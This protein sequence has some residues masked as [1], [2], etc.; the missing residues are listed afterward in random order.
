[1]AKGIMIPPPPW[2]EEIETI[3]PP[4]WE[5]DQSS[6]LMVQDSDNIPPPPWEEQDQPQ[7]DE[8]QFQSW[9]AGHAKTRGL[10][11]NPDDPEHYYDYRAAFKAGAGPGPDGHWP[12]Q[13]KTE[14]H[15]RTIVDG[16]NTITGQPVNE[17]PD[18]FSNAARKAVDITNAI[19]KPIYLT[20]GSPL[21]TPAKAIASLET[22]GPALAES[23]QKNIGDWVSS[24]PPENLSPIQQKERQ[25]EKALLAGIT[26]TA[27]EILP[28]S[29][30]QALE[31]ELFGAGT[32]ALAK[33]VRAGS[34]LNKFVGEYFPNLAEA[35]FKE[36]TVLTP[37]MQGEL[38]G[39]IFRVKKAFGVPQESG[40]I[41]YARELVRKAE[42]APEAERKILFKRA[43][44]MDSSIREEMIKARG[45]D[46][47]KEVPL[48]PEGSS[49]PKARPIDI[50]KKPVLQSERPLSDLVK[51]EQNIKP[52]E[53]PQVDLSG[54]PDQVP[55]AQPEQSVAVPT[56]PAATG[57]EV[58]PAKDTL[59]MTMKEPE[60]MSLI[61]R[62]NSIVKNSKNFKDFKDQMLSD[63]KLIDAVNFFETSLSEIH[64][65]KNEKNII[66]PISRMEPP[67]VH[68]MM[69]VKI[70][71]NVDG[72]INWGFS[73]MSVYSDGT[74]RWLWINPSTA[75]KLHGEGKTIKEIGE[76]IADRDKKMSEELSKI[77]PSIKVYGNAQKLL[78]EITE[79][80]PVPPEVI[81]DYPDLGKSE[82]SVLP[83]VNLVKRNESDS[84]YA[85]YDVLSDAGDN[86]GHVTDVSVKGEDDGMI[87]LVPIIEKGKGYGQ[88][89]YIAMAKL[90]PDKRIISGNLSPDA[91]RMW[92]S[93][94]KKGFADREKIGEYPNGETEWQYIL[95]KYADIQNF[96]TPP[97]K[98]PWE[99]TQRAYVF[100]PEGSEPN[101]SSPYAKE[102]GIQ[103][104]SPVYPD[105]RNKAIS[106]HANA[107]RV[108]LS[109][110]KPVPQEVL[111][112]YPELA[113]PSP[114][115]KLLP[116]KTMTS[117]MTDAV[118]QSAI[119]LKKEIS[120][121]RYGDKGK[122]LFEF[123]GTTY[124]VDEP[125]D[126]MPVG[127]SDQSKSWALK[128]VLNENAKRIN[129]VSKD[130]EDALNDAYD[131]IVRVTETQKRLL[132]LD[133]IYGNGTLFPL[134]TK[135][136]FGRVYNVVK[137]LIAEKSSASPVQKVEESIPVEKQKEFTSLKIDE[138]DPKLIKAQVIEKLK[139]IEKQFPIEQSLIQSVPNVDLALKQV[140]TDS[141]NAPRKARD[142]VDELKKISVGDKKFRIKIPDDGT[143]TVEPTLYA[144][145]QAI[146]IFSK[147]SPS[148][149]EPVTGTVEVKNYPAGTEG[150]GFEI[151][152]S[153]I[154]KIIKE[155]ETPLKAQNRI[156]KELSYE[157]DLDKIKNIKKSGGGGSSSGGQASRGASA[158]DTFER[159]ITGDP[160]PAQ[161]LQTSKEVQDIYDEFGITVGERHVEG[162]AG[163]FYTKTKNV[164]VQSMNNV[165]VSL[166]EAAHNRD[167][168]HG[169]TKKI[170]AKTDTSEKGNPVYVR[171]YKTVREA[172]TD[173][174]VKYYPKGKKNHK[175]S[176]RIK[177]GYATFIE[178]YNE[179]PTQMAA[180]YPEL[181]REII[182]AGGRLHNTDVSK[183]MAKF[184]KIIERY[185]A[186][187]PID[188]VGS[189]V[190][191]IRKQNGIT[192]GFLNFF[193]KV[194][195]QT[196]D[197]VH[198]LVKLAKQAGVSRTSTDPSLW[199]RQYG[200]SSAMILNN[201]KGDGFWTIS[202]GDF[203]KVSDK[204][205][206]DLTIMLQESGDTKKFNDWLVARD[207][208]FGFEEL[209]QLKQEAKQAQE[210]LKHLEDAL[211]EEGEVSATDI[212]E[213]IK[214][215]KIKI[216]TYQE[217]VR[218]MSKNG[219]DSAVVRQ[220]YLDFKDRFIE[221]EKLFDLF[222]NANLK[223]LL[224]SR[225]ITS[226][227]Y[228]ELSSK[229]G[230]SP[231][232]RDI[233]DEVLGVG[234]ETLP[235][236]RTGPTRVSSMIR[237]RG[238][239]LDIIDPLASLFQDHA[240]IVRKSLKQIVVNKIY[241]ISG[242]FPGL[243][244]QTKLIRQYD[245]ET[246]ITKYPQDKDPD[247]I[248]A[249][250]ANGK[251]VPL[252]ASREIQMAINDLFGF[253]ELNVFERLMRFSARMFTQ[254]TTGA[255]PLFAPSNFVVDQ[256]TAAAQTRN[257]FIPLYDPITKIVKA[258]KDHDSPEARYLEA[259]LAS[260]GE[261]QTF[262]RWQDLP[263]DEL[264][265]VISGEKTALEKVGASID[266]GMHYVSWLSSKSEMMTRA[267]EYIK[268][269]Q[270]G[271]PHIVALEDAGQVSI[272]F[273]HIGSWGGGTVGKTL[274]KSSVFFNPGLQAIFKYG[275]TLGDKSTRNRALFVTLA[276]I[277]SSI[278][279]MFY[280]MK[281]ATKKQKDLYNDLEANELANYMWFP[282][283]DGERLWKLKIPREMG[284]IATVINMGLA[285]LGMGGS[286]GAKDFVSG[287]TAF[288]PDQINITDPVR[289]FFTLLPQILKPGLMVLVG[290]KDWPKLRPMESK[291]LENK[292]PRYRFSENTSAYA[293]W[294]GDKL[295]LSPIKIDY[296]IEGYFGRITRFA[297]WKPITNPFTREYYFTA[298]RNLQDYYE[299]R[300][301]TKFAHTAMRLGLQKPNDEE[302]RQ[303]SQKMQIIKNT[304][305]L[306]DT[307]RKTDSLLRAS[308]E[309]DRNKNER[310]ERLRRAILDN[311]GTL[312]GVGNVESGQM[313]RRRDARAEARR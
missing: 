144:V 164:R 91:E 207:Q 126:V 14:G 151:I 307:Y 194:F 13:F 34:S 225:K 231:L 102:M 285:N 193:D 270:A 86:V 300:D 105:Q 31:Y 67:P 65:R 239:E 281:R 296:L 95:K 158:I 15:P 38:N 1:M 308:G 6:A 276:V 269:R 131:F 39:A 128:Q 157:M 29:P 290:K 23:A 268:S 45:M 21:F 27:L 97:A 109:E 135:E 176:K 198:P 263:P 299:I 137:D 57:S 214:A 295:N 30:S 244:Q 80:R 72:K 213:A 199:A 56:T 238:S 226:K 42:S 212:K 8:Q 190:V 257:K 177:E 70:D 258:L 254:G 118:N 125:S 255:Y 262:A 227:Q 11:P 250:D 196:I 36:R 62:I 272:P 10:N 26:S 211:P 301:R 313:Y 246:G 154:D 120:P 77:A 22:M 113:K 283:P 133:D 240:E 71:R 33:S 232:K 28:H 279:S 134:L 2:E 16:V 297:T 175:L 87:S 127:D 110:G 98:E 188:K 284:A 289:A 165:S 220:A 60:A 163:L 92:L 200:N 259:Y 275:A 260:G 149:F 228:V 162:N 119:E 59:K 178:K 43:A 75:M 156:K 93:F 117:E 170:L 101:T 218:V 51:A 111:K 282:S 9:Y 186:S 230:Y 150:A 64:D 152:K 40:L 61:P 271:N 215:A 106:W 99:M 115:S 124:Q 58:A 202:N 74:K 37:A 310:T 53:L 78:N 116:K 311:I 265:R 108:A 252:L 302:K 182:Y 248:M 306:L 63:K 166:H 123:K 49:L 181:V 168:K 50:V 256:F 48:P 76:Y 294:M 19:P 52:T 192:S 187:S 55:S 146:R 224:E 112:D 179:Q 145:K 264:Y 7:D 174:Y 195:T 129:K 251:R 229:K 73:S 88:A 237:R 103:D 94:F 292:E 3:P 273:H 185:Q 217:M 219:F 148:V 167:D 18:L 249:R 85:V 172:L 169:I 132:P 17:P 81:K 243:F 66:Q 291:S 197:S 267:S 32:K 79:G 130:Q 180:D 84:D 96:P 138:S 304:E 233:Y 261:R 205:L 136:G 82:P 274:V 155:S 83:V 46:Q 69:K 312:R 90:F 44:Q 141:K 184:R 100:G 4:P 235:A 221:E 303:I 222:T 160:E 236:P 201:I 107:V 189:R 209:D 305:H 121:V 122:L 5:I 68:G 204:N 183:M 253:K 298:G 191:S 171:A 206:G 25:M 293:K 147:A 309:T 54:I 47:S 140:L 139:E 210:Q 104:F 203:V 208:H 12:S 288:L 286:F 241:D 142:L 223:L 173:V 143:F 89:A 247:I 41:S 287:A 277:A 245:P 161:K 114:A 35:I 278:G 24:A 242:H 216:K 153:K 20:T 234:D 280:L 159:N 266:F